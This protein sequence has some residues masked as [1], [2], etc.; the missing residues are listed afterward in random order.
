MICLFFFEKNQN[1][2]VLSINV[3]M[4]NVEEG[5]LRKQLTIEALQ[6]LDLS[7]IHI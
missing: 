5:N 3:D 7:L 6:A 2:W 1:R 4:N